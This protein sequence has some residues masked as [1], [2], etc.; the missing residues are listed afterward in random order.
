MTRILFG[1]IAKAG[2]D[3]V[4]GGTVGRDTVQVPPDKVATVY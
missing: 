3:F 1:S 4:V 2:S